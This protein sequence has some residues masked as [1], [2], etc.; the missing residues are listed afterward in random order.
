MIKSLDLKIKDKGL[1][2]V[3][4]ITIVSSNLVFL[5]ESN[6]IPSYELTNYLTSRAIANFFVIIACFG[7][8]FRPD[9]VFCHYVYTVA[10][11]GYMIQGN[12]FRPDYEFSYIQYLIA[13]SLFFK[14]SRKGFLIVHFIGTLLFLISMYFNFEANFQRKM[15]TH[16]FA[17]SISIMIICFMIGWLVFSRFTKAREEKDKSQSKFLLVGKQ[18]VNIIHDLKSLASAPQI[19]LEI[20][21]ANRNQI[22]PDTERILN[23]L[24]DDLTNMVKKTKDL[25]SMVQNKEFSSDKEIARL[26]LS[27]VLLFMKSRLEGVDLI[28][29]GSS[30]KEISKGILELIL[31]NLFYNS[32][33]AFKKNRIESPKIKITLTED[34]ISYFDNAGGAEENIISDFNAN[35]IGSNEGLGLYL[36]SDAARSFDLDVRLSNKSVDRSKGLEVQILC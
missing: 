2:W 7:I 15:V 17:D 16:S 24:Q 35:R 11:Y 36:I 28:I 29:E 21:L 23:Q 19:Y 9:V 10:A 34:K 22:D 14:Q 3:G 33:D 30:S 6:L 25:Y 5:Y 8:M 32:L 27:K 4:I 20:L 26:T 12:F 1:F 31:L 18:A 13:Q